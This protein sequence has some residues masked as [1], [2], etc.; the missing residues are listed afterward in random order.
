MLIKLKSILAVLFVASLMITLTGCG[1][2]EEEETTLPPPKAQGS[3]T[4]PEQVG[5]GDSGINKQGQVDETT[6]YYEI[7]V[8]PG[9][10]Y[11]ITIVPVSADVS[12]SLYSDMFTT[13]EC[14]SDNAGT[15]S[16]VCTIIP[17]TSP[18]YFS[19]D[20]ANTTAGSYFQIKVVAG[21]VNEGTAANPV[22]LGPEPLSYDGQVSQYGKSYYKVGV[23]PGTGYRFKV[24]SSSKY[25]LHV[26]SDSAFTTPVC[27]VSDGYTDANE[28]CLL[29]APGSE[30]FLTVSDYSYADTGIRHTL[31][32]TTAP[33]DEGTNA[34]P[35]D[36][37]SALPISFTGQVSDGKHALYTY[38]SYYSFDTTPGVGYKISISNP[39]ATSLAFAASTGGVEV[40]SNAVTTSCLFTAKDALAKI[41]VFTT[42]GNIGGAYYT[43]EVVNAPAN[44]GAID[45][46]VHLG[47]APAGTPLNYTGGQVQQ[48][49]SYYVLSVD[50][51]STYEILTSGATEE[52]VLTIYSGEGFTG[53]I[54]PH[55]Q[56]YSGND[57]HVTL[58][59]TGNLLYIR[60]EL[61]DK[62]LDGA[63]FTLAANTGY[64]D[65][66]TLDVPITLDSSTFPV[67]YNSGQVG[68]GDSYYMLTVDPNTYYTVSLSGIT[69]V[70]PYNVYLD[71]SE[72]SGGIPITWS[73]ICCSAS[74]H[75]TLDAVF[76]GGT[77][78]TTDKMLI[79]VR[80]IDSFNGSGYTL[81]VDS[82]PVAEGELAS[83]LDINPGQELSPANKS[84]TYAGSVSM[85]Y[86]YYKVAVEPGYTY[87]VSLLNQTGDADLYVT[88]DFPWNLSP[89]ADCSSKNTVT[90]DERCDVKAVD[91]T[92]GNS[93]LHIKV[94]GPY[95]L[96]SE[97]SLKVEQIW[98]TEG[99]G[100]IVNL[101]TAPVTD[102]QG[103]VS[104]LAGYYGYSYYRVSINTGV[105]YEVFISGLEQG[106]QVMGSH[107]SDTCWGG[108]S[109]TFSG[110][111]LQASAAD[112]TLDVEVQ[113]TSTIGTPF[114]LTVR[115]IPTYTSEG[116]IGS[117]ISVTGTHEG[118][119]GVE[120]SSYYSLSVTENTAVSVALTN[121]V[122]NP[123][124][125]YVKNLGNTTTY[126]TGVTIAPKMAC[127]ATVPAGT[128]ELLVVVYG[129]NGS[130]Y[131]LT[132]TESTNLKQGTLAT[133]LDLA[134]NPFNGTVD[135]TESFYSLS[136]AAGSGHVLTFTNTGNPYAIF[137]I[138]DSGANLL[139][140][141]T[142]LDAGG[143]LSLAVTTPADG[144]LVIKAMP[145]SASGNSARQY[146]S[147][148]TIEEAPSTNVSQGSPSSPVALTAVLLPYSASVDSTTSYYRYSGTTAGKSYTVSMA[149]TGYG[150]L[151]V[152]GADS[153]Y[154]TVVCGGGVTDITG[155]DACTIT[156]NGS[157]IFFKITEA[158][159][160]GGAFT[161]NVT[162][163]TNINEG[164]TTPVVLTESTPLAGTVDSTFSQYEI[165][166]LPNA[167][168]YTVS[169]SGST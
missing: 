31:A 161:L 150:G 67:V 167:T 77:G 115:E 36:L 48:Q 164:K 131:T 14:T 65:E 144:T 25:G 145:F 117:P 22:N 28:N 106:A 57:H 33:A 168:Y 35:I 153:T 104:K 136:A 85:G 7:T 103:Q 30:M 143:Q 105:L 124:S 114:L 141:T 2:E 80:G 99:D 148:F 61:S 133:P 71:V 142:Q 13:L 46:P 79:R 1:G 151:Y 50:A 92:I 5:T 88:D 4:E 38:T 132:A 90:N 93:F 23:T 6:S 3:L 55:A 89:P 9:T 47:S 110:C 108:W 53:V 123:A 147:S 149:K 102:Y 66:G 95:T 162:E 18:V 122:E 20:G 51:G 82:G 73:S 125:L 11:T 98:V 42:G 17:E 113:T 24:T 16:E 120:G 128:T 45:A 84:V 76:E 121:Y 10:G 134:S 32:V 63:T 56:T 169:L 26:Y 155:T 112:I 97:Y 19:V 27:E 49:Y 86:S 75:S 130:S 129:S 140:Q 54:I 43:L 101:G 118:Q 78:A 158:G 52:M 100:S 94:D 12:L 165:T 68:H 119:V 81:T 138:Y 59:T 62:T 29:K 74:G 96:G 87:R 34:N 72:G 166:G 37:G 21:N 60:A 160:L 152:Y 107:N 159:Y 137:Y 39:S 116:S 15:A 154:T 139:Q 111:L 40:C 64:Q 109:S 58:T 69:A 156:S 135:S 127:T 157:D 8:T 70:V 163:G 44:V 146:G 91:G 126:C 83:P 41:L